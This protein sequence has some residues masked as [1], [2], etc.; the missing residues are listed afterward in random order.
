MHLLLLKL[1]VNLTGD[2]YY[3]ICRQH[4]L[5]Y[6]VP[7]SI[8]STPKLTLIRI[9]IYS[10]NFILIYIKYCMNRPTFYKIYKK[11]SAEGYQSVPYVVALFSAMLWIYYALLK[12]NA[13]FLITIN[14]F[15]C[16]IESLYI[17]L[18]IIYAPTKLR[19]SFNLIIVYSNIIHLIIINYDFKFNF[20][21]YY[22]F[23][24]TNLIW[25]CAMHACSSKR[26]RL[27]FC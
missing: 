14:S 19:V 20:I 10:F 13:T 6:G 9:Q 1:F 8:V 27:Y 3:V 26:L 2:I 22:G 21:S 7:S 4:Y 12:T 25:P 23:I 24:G 18:F 15:G 16:V 5:F 17:L 11:K